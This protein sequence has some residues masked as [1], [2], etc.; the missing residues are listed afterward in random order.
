MWMTDKQGAFGGMKTGYAETLPSA[1]LSKW[2]TLR[3]NPGLCS[4]ELVL[5][6]PFLRY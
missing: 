2:M 6:R 5:N 3:W 4:E 1:T